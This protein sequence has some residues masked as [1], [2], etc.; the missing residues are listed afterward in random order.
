MNEE[1]P[2]PAGDPGS[3][4]SGGDETNKTSGKGSRLI[5]RILPA[6]VRFWLRS[7]VE[8]VDSLSLALE[9]RDRQL[10]SGY[11]PGVSV[12]A[13]QA[14]Y[15]GIHIGQLQLSAQDIRIN[16]GQVVRG[17]PLRLLKVFPVLGEVAL[18]SDDLNASLSSEL[19]A[20]GLRDFWQSLLQIPALAEE[21]EIDMVRL[22]CSLLWCCP[23]PVFGWAIAHWR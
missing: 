14:I 13:E 15:Q 4:S 7:Q 2:M 23:V 5:G 8:Q 6:A 3:Q 21:V 12:S 1:S 18:T 10:L 20:G 22:R 9:G 16:V 17:K 19:L 11:L